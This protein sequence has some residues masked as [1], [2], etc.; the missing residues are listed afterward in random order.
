MTFSGN[1]GLEGRTS[2]RKGSVPC[3]NGKALLREKT[4]T[5][6]FKWTRYIG[7]GGDALESSSFT[8]LFTNRVRKRAIFNESG[9]TRQVRETA[10]ET[11][12]LSRMDS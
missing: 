11:S 1:L 12:C 2:L 4:K 3:H 5:E 6:N 8:S 9:T 10:E 7:S